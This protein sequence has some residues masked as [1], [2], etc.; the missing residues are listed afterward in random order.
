MLY[1]KLHGWHTRLFLCCMIYISFIAQWYMEPFSLCNFIADSILY[2]LD[3]S[4]AISLRWIPYGFTDDKL[5]LFQVMVSPTPLIKSKVIKFYVAICLH[6]GLMVY[7]LPALCQ[8]VSINVFISLTF[9]NVAEK[10]GLHYVFKC[11]QAFKVLQRTGDTRSDGTMIL[12]A[13]GIFSMFLKCN[14]SDRTIVT[15]FWLNV[16]R[17]F[18]P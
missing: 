5:I 11:K 4:S 17:I 16:N 14:T 8:D 12:P 9:P 15:Y 10:K 18:L 1:G 13:A 3:I 2:I 7:M 6:Q